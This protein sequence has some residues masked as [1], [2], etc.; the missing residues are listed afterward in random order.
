MVGDVWFVS[1]PRQTHQEIPLIK[2]LLICLH[3][4]ISTSTHLSASLFPS[5]LLLYH[6]SLRQPGMRATYPC[7][8]K[9]GQ[10]ARLSS[11]LKGWDRH[12]TKLS[13]TAKQLRHNSFSNRDFQVP[14]W[15]GSPHLS[16]GHTW[17]GQR[18]PW[19][20]V[21]AHAAIK[22]KGT[23]GNIVIWR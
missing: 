14:P 15:Q 12:I 1:W 23:A 22:Q 5:F 6:I 16:W 2:L 19:A 20:I 11:R 18:T 21:L 7:W 3:F 9:P 10:A 13:G 4:E 17:N 8:H